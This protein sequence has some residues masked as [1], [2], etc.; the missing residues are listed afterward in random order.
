M[1]AQDVDHVVKVQGNTNAIDVYN[2]IMELGSYINV[3]RSVS[4]INTAFIKVAARILIKVSAR[5]RTKDSARMD[6]KDLERTRDGRSSGVSG[7]AECLGME[8]MVMGPL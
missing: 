7:E 6:R 8:V 4:M 3:L 1:G 2:L 5:M